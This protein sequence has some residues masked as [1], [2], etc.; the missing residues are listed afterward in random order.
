MLPDCTNLNGDSVSS[1]SI[2]TPQGLGNNEEGDEVDLT[3]GGLG[4][5]NN[6]ST[7]TVQSRT[8]ITVT[9]AQDETPQLPKISQTQQKTEE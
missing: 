6:S 3:L 4:S 2:S 9:A 5:D 7:V 1:S 8:I